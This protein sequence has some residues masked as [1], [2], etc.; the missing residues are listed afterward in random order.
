[1]NKA[2]LAGVCFPG[3]LL[4]L[5]LHLLFFC[6]TRSFAK[7]P[8]PVDQVLISL[9]I[10][11]VGT[12]DIPAL[13]I[14]EHAYL[15]VTEL[16]DL[17]KI[18]NIPSTDLSTIHG[19]II[20]PNALFEID[21]GKNRITYRGKIF[22]MNPDDMR[23]TE[24]GIY[25]KTELY[26]QVFGL[27]CLLK[28]RSLSI[29]LSTKLELPVIRDLRLTQ[30]RKN[31]SDLR[32]LK[33][34][35]TTLER[36]YPLFDLGVA[37]WSVTA[38]QDN[39]GNASSRANLNLGGIVAGGQA[40]ASLNYNTGMPFNSR[41][42]YY[43]W[44]YVNNDNTAFKQITAGR[45]FTQSISSVFNPVNGVQITNTPTT[46]RRSFGTYRINKTTEPGWTAELYVNNVLVN[47]VVADASGFYSFDVP[48][49]YGNSSIK[50]RVYGPFGEEHT[51]EQGVSI[52][53]NFL[54]P[55]QFEYTMSAGV[56]DNLE[57]DILTRAAMSYGLNDRVTIGA[58]TEYLSSANLGQPMA[59][60]NSSVR[61]LQGLLLSGQYT[62][63]V[64]TKG[65]LNYQLPG[66]IQLDVNYTKYDKE[67]TAIL[68]NYR[69]ERKVEVSIPI[70]GKNFNAYSRI[71]FNQYVLPNS[72]VTNAQ[73]MTSASVAGIGLNFST[74]A[75]YTDPAKPYI[76]SNL[77][78]TFRLPLNLRFSPH[79]QYE[80]K[81]QKVSMMKAEME[82]RLGSFGFATI[83]YEKSIPNKVTSINLGL[84]L[85]FSF[86]QTFYGVTQANHSTFLVQSAY[87][88]LLYNSKRNSLSL[89][90]ESNVGKGG[91]TICAFLDVNNNG[92]RD[93]TEPRVPGLKLK[94]NGGRIKRNETDTTINITGLEG[95]ANY[96]IQLDA[97]SFDNISWR[98][99]NKTIGVTIEPNHYRLI[100]LPVSVVA[101]A[102]GTVYKNEANEKKALAGMIVEIFNS[103][104]VLVAKVL[105]EEDGY[106]NFIGLAPGKY[107]ARLNDAQLQVL[108]LKSMPSIPFDIKMSRDGDIVDTLNFEL[109][110][111]QVGKIEGSTKEK[112]INKKRTGR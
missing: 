31:I 63:G 71:S 56:V 3:L 32:G 57:K 36:D 78:L 26:G 66:N 25:L 59:F 19:F 69:E 60:V 74:N 49:V 38:S 88:S 17:L 82:K 55:G 50:I 39:L 87:G 44:R 22:K 20:D 92:R 70:T 91:I 95:Y 48:L 109:H 46:Y 28:F 1:M 33:K 64:N 75:L 111:S 84:R 68:Y 53:F 45:I 51:S 14:N 11:Q 65:I 101:E 43:Q 67:Q 34:A 13:L 54:P 108:K 47:Y 96:I 58:G 80:Y 112:R 29:V 30:M 93:S 105:T 5:T 99:K 83:A 104:G 15:P 73:F 35:D 100:E 85:N 89:S 98:L 16:F 37:D 4:S 2:R 110:T 41:E 79:L 107:I 72:K 40:V 10:E 27:E 62:P 61:L 90:N 76:Y 97:N 77:S 102:S 24:S 103:K 52:P 106:F 94:L 23:R 8:E 21:Y 9:K 6:N 86:A 12:F 7:E 18:R 42:Q 81:Q